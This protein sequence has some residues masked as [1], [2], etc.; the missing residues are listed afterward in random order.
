M[1]AI[2]PCRHVKP[3]GK[4]PQKSTTM[5]KAREGA[6][7]LLLTIGMTQAAMAFI[8]PGILQ[9][10]VDLDRMKT[11]VTANAQP[12]KSGYDK[13]AAD[14]FSL[15]TYTPQGY[16]STVDRG[17][18]NL[19]RSKFANDVQ[20]AYQQALMWSIT[21]STTYR[22]KALTIIKGWTN[23][24]TTFT[25]RDA[26]LLVGLNGFK[27]VN[28][29]EIMR[30]NN[31]GQ[32]SAT[33]IT[34]TENWFKNKWIPWLLPTGAPTGALDGNWGMAA[35]KCQAAIGVF[36]NDQS[37][38]NSGISGLTSGCA[39]IQ[40][41]IKGDA[42]Y[43]GEETETG[44]DNGHWQLA[45]GDMAEGAQVGFNQGRDLFALGGNRLLAA[46]EYFCKYQ[47]GTNVNY[48]PWKTCLTAKNYKAISPRSTVYRPI[49]ELILNHY[50]A[51]AAPNTKI[52]ADAHRPEGSVGGAQSGDSTGFGTIL[53]TVP[54]A[55]PIDERLLPH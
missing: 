3:A 26:Q 20:A 8:H 44:R 42:T 46:F 35:L 15:K 37:Q 11:Q 10:Q 31:G 36:T 34:N 39:S 47:L 53:Y 50:G 29:A 2:H 12:W 41:S 9:T 48:T 23:A 33:D 22:D 19:N 7:V 51:A 14:K 40:D 13:L 4:P 45:I 32:W 18:T 54:A 5:K 55:N 27:F 21:G 25:G 49:F 6:I 17:T 16:T 28:A 43:L 30:Y 24:N 52:V 1:D 38:F